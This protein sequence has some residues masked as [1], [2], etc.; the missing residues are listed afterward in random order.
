VICLN[1]FNSS[2]RVKSSQ[3]DRINPNDWVVWRDNF[4]FKQIQQDPV[5]NDLSNTK[6]SQLD[7]RLD[8]LNKQ[9]QKLKWARIKNKINRLLKIIIR[10]CGIVIGL[11]A[12]F[13]MREDIRKGDSCYASQGDFVPVYFKEKEGK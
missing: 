11:F 10:G 9:Q 13:K 8:S 12:L 5:F 4:D 2:E 1:I 7:N 3:Y 6:L